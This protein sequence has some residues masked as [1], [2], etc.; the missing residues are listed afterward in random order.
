MIGWDAQEELPQ[1]T[2]KQEAFIRALL[3]GLTRVARLP[4]KRNNC[5]ASVRRS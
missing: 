5:Q 4:I 2:P 3:E 1:L